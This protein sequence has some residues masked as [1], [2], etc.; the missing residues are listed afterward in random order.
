[1]KALFKCTALLLVLTI[2][3]GCSRSTALQDSTR[4]ALIAKQ[5]CEQLY[6]SIRIAWYQGRVTE[7]EIALARTLI[8]KYFVAQ[9]AW[10]A[11]LAQAQAEGDVSL[12]SPGRRRRIG[13]AASTVADCI[14]GLTKI[15]IAIRERGEDND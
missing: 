12:S 2:L 14:A 7:E 9:S 8:E 11:E 10:Q 6:I 3:A 15:W 13:E 1:M 4:K 5:A